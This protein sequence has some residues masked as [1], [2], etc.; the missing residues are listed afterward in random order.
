LYTEF[1][2]EIN[3]V[4]LNPQNLPISP[5]RK[6]FS[7]AIRRLAPTL[8]DLRDESG[9]PARNCE[10]Y[11]SAVGRGADDGIAGAVQWLHSRDTPVKKWFFFFLLIAA[12]AGGYYYWQGR[13]GGQTLNEKTLTFAEVRR[14]TMRDTV[15]ATGLIEPREI[16]VVSSKTPGTVLR[17][18]GQVGDS[19]V[20]GAELAYLDERQINLKI[21]EAKN[22]IHLT[23][24]ALLHAQALVT[25]AQAAKDAAWA[26]LEIQTQL[27]KTAGLRSDR[28]QAEAQ[29]KAALAGIK[30]AEAG[31]DMAKAKAAAAQTALQEAQLVRDMA[32]IKVPGESIHLPGA[33]KREF[34]ILD[35]KLHEGQMVGPQ[36]GPVYTLAGALDI[37][38][39]H[40]QVA[41]GDINKVKAGLAALFKIA[42][43]SDE[44]IEFVGTVARKRWQANSVKGAV[45]YDTVI[46]VKN[47]K[48][49]TTKEWL[50]R[51]GMTVSV[52]M[53]RLERKNVWRVPAAATNF[54]LEEAYQSDAVK[55][56]VAKWKQR[57]DDWFP[58]WTWDAARG[59]PTPVFVRINGTKKDEFALKDAEGIEVLEWEPKTE[60]TGPLR[61]IIGAP[62][63]RAPGLLDQPANVKL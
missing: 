50:L 61:V 45:Y 27:A 53:V 22:G 26:A 43:Y 55:A 31:I 3:A 39:V 63:A 38:E 6:G 57:P 54:K 32:R 29:Y 7:N 44:D 58:I 40:A 18:V 16:V 48:D 49:P 28:E 33:A 60:P 35:R 41:E 25:Q 13:T 8:R 24:A 37:V 36:T 62:P 12:G 1:F 15:S 19:V 14:T 5:S 23:N 17:I 52:D 4:S 9:L 10:G 51:P 2:V 56:Q 34:L 30:V 11:S 47:R 59:E 46:D 42:N 20:E 21:E